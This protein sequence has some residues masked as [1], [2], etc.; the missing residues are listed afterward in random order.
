MSRAY[1]IRVREQLKRILHAGD[2]VSTR[3]ELLEILAPDEMTS[4][5]AEELERRGFKRQE[6]ALT[7]RQGEVTV[8]IEP[9]SATVTVQAEI[10]EQVKLRGE[11][12]GQGYE[13]IG[14]STRQAKAALRE[15][16]RSELEHEAKQRS[17]ELA[18]RVANQLEG[19]LIDLRGEL[20]QIVNRVTAEALKRKAGR[21]GRIK[22]MTEDQE[23]GS[24]TI[25]LEV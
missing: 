21:L 12:V 20:D 4:L 14:P 8:T 3:L 23:T 11:K 6:K 22:E 7:R 15:Q 25:V 24:L 13:D 1:R 2:R 10:S 19:Q 5:L 17:A 16:L 18:T 9:E